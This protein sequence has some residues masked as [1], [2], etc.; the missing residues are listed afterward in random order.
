MGVISWESNSIKQGCKR[1]FI[2]RQIL[3]IADEFCLQQLVKEPMRKDRVLDLFFTSNNTLVDQVTVT[4]GI[5]DH[6]GI[7]LIDMSTKPKLNKQKPRK[8][9]LYNKVDKN[10]LNSDL[11]DMSDRI[12][13]DNS[14]KSVK[15]L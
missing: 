9:F 1:P 13:E 8:T 6:D 12:T 7:P 11:K 14:S 10:K 2:F 15:E 5:S 4:P 3:D